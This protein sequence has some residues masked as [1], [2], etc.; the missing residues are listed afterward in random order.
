MDFERAV[1]DRNI[2]DI[3]NILKDKNFIV[4]F[5]ILR[6]CVLNIDL[7]SA[8]DYVKKEEINFYYYMLHKIKPTVDNYNDPFIFWPIMSILKN[9]FSEN[10]VIKLIEKSLEY[11]CSF[12]NLLN[13]RD[14]LY[15]LYYDERSETLFDFLWKN[16]YC[17]NTLYT[18]K[19]FNDD[20]RY[21]IHKFYVKNK[22]VI[23]N[24]IHKSAKFSN[25]D[26][27]PFLLSEDLE[28][29]LD[30]TKKGTNVSSMN[31]IIIWC[32]NPKLKKYETSSLYIKSLFMKRSET[33]HYLIKKSCLQWIFDNKLPFDKIKV[34][35]NII[36]KSKKND[37]KQLTKHL[38]DTI[39]LYKEFTISPEEFLQNICKTVAD[40]LE[41]R[42]K[43]MNSD[44]PFLLNDDELFILN[45]DINKI[46]TLYGINNEDKVFLLSELK[47]GDIIYI[48]HINPSLIKADF[49][50]VGKITYVEHT[51]YENSSNC[52][53]RI[54]CKVKLGY[55][56]ELII[57]QEIIGNQNRND[58]ID[59]CDYQQGLI[60]RQSIYDIDNFDTTNLV[61]LKPSVPTLLDLS[62]VNIRSRFPIYKLE[63][64]SCLP[65]EL[66]E[67]IWKNSIYHI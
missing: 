46:K 53:Y 37:D 63:L 65:L 52:I 29:F 20:Q 24:I 28:F 6:D 48:N 7:S 47:I 36:C 62:V 45:N 3:E 16:G 1:L 56:E 10:E 34:I 12:K 4:P 21:L 41:F 5:Y 67:I 13:G 57:K 17:I 35:E 26:L 44:F 64:E 32:L 25:D 55:T 22:N 50:D 9:H 39:K 19:N 8:S 61:I 54:K 51:K 60:P 33:D 58:M 15:Q 38:I 11:G 27:I 30:I 31:S 66:V 43:I 40:Y 18:Q 59:I 49:S 42:Y 23:K 14:I 2:L